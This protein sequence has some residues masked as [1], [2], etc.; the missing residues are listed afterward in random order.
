MVSLAEL[1]NLADISSLQI[2]EP[3]RHN[4]GDHIAS[5]YDEAP[6]LLGSKLPQEMFAPSEGSGDQD[7]LTTDLRLRCS[8]DCVSRFKPFIP[9]FVLALLGAGMQ[10][11]GHI[12]SSSR[13]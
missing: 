2:H 4:S 12:P 8:G 9:S 13:G 1:E 5:E 7:R 6:C 3:G 11:A 10:R